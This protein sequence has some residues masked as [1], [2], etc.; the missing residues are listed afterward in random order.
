MPF[1]AVCAVH[2]GAA[3]IDWTQEEIHE[4]DIKTRKILC[5]FK[6]LHPEAI[7][8][9]KEW[10]GRCNDMHDCIASEKTKPQ[11]AKNKEELFSMRDIRLNS[12]I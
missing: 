12:K 11:F 7:R 10:R 9:K 4:M 5:E 6:A 2:S 1:W 3:I 8:A